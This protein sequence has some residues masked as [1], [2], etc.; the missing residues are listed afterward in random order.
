MATAGGLVFI[1]ATWDHHLRAID[2]ETGRELW[3]AAL[4]VGGYAMPMTYA[5]NGRQYVVIAAGGH[6]RLDPNGM[7]DYVLA[8]T[9]G[10]SGAPALDTAAHSAAGTFG[11]EIR[12][13]DDRHPAHFTLR[14]S[15]DSLVGEFDI[16]DPVAQGTVSGRQTGDTIVF[17]APPLTAGSSPLSAFHSSEK[18]CDGVF[19]GRGELADGGRLFVGRVLLTGPCSG[20]P[21]DSGSFGVWRRP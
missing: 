1:A 20:T 12:T 18:K 3:S 2:V 16:T 8:F 17:T 4:P 19:A 15:G 7:G 6:D 21:P 9:L 11:G 5:V 10:G 14:A 13:G